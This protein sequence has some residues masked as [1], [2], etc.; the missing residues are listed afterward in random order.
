MENAFLV[1][2]INP[3]GFLTPFFI[4]VT[5]ARIND[6]EDVS[7][8]INLANFS[9]TVSL[10]QYQNFLIV[11]RTRHPVITLMDS[12]NTLNQVNSVCLLLWNV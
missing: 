7:L 10:F 2:I 11:I 4:K 6:L 9:N 12:L 5:S 8:I 3:R 1:M